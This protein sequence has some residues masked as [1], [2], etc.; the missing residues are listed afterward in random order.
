MEVK[1]KNERDMKM[2]NVLIGVPHRK[3]S[4]TE[5]WDRNNVWR[6]IALEFLK[7][8]GIKSQID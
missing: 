3:E 8:K 6:N 1:K 4:K 5:T 2:S 7:L